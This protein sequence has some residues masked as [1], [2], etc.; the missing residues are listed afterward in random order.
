MDLNL[1]LQ[2][3]LCDILLHLPGQLEQL[4]QCSG[5]EQAVPS[6]PEHQGQFAIVVGHGL[7]YWG[8]LRHVHQAV[9]VFDGFVGF[10]LR[11]TCLVTV[12]L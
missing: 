11:Q 7:G 6:L 9:D 1:L 2:F 12:G 5:V 4:Q 8:L 10:L 3:L